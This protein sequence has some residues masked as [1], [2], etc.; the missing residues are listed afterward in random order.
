VRE[1]ISEAELRRLAA[2]SGVD[3]MVQDLDYAL[4]W[5]LAGLL[6]QHPASDYLIFKGGTCLRKCYFPEYRFSEDLDFTLAQ[7][8]EVAGLQVAIQKVQQWSQ[9]NGG[10]DFDAAPARWEIINDEYGQES[11]Q[12]RIYYRG[13]LRWGGPA[14]AIQVD[15]S[16]GET[17]VFPAERHRLIH[18]YS[19]RGALAAVELP[20]YSLAEMLAEKVRAIAGQRRFA[21]SRD[22]YD[23]CQLSRQGVPAATVRSSLPAKFAAKG[24]D[25]ESFNLDRLNERRQAME[26]DWNRRLVHLLPSD[27]L[28]AFDAAWQA[29][30]EFIQ[31]V[32]ASP[33]P[34]A[35]N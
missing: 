27:Q 11:L 6:R 9:E 12:G 22:L 17:M 25:L 32:L 3:V 29:V 5:F 15:I 14:R 19:D 34:R 4:G 28:I 35:A 16:R 30:T 18:P 23:I 31:E 26:A 21:V 13:P 8:W 2:R 20:C 1:V 7:H 24:V 33:S 10:P